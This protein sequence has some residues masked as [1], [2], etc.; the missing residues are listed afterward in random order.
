MHTHQIPLRRVGWFLLAI[1][2]YLI[3]VRVFQLL[4][5]FVVVC[6]L[7]MSAE[8]RKYCCNFIHTRAHTTAQMSNIVHH[9]W[10]ALIKPLYKMC[11]SVVLDLH[12]KHASINLCANKKNTDWQ[13][14]VKL[15]L[16]GIHLLKNGVR[17]RAQIP[18]HKRKRKQFEWQFFHRISSNHTRYTC[19][20][21]E[22]SVLSA[23]QLIRWNRVDEPVINC[24]LSIDI[25]NLNLKRK[26][27]YYDLAL[28]Q[29]EKAWANK[30][31]IKKT[32]DN[33]CVL[34]EGQNKCRNAQRPHYK[35]ESK[36][37]QMPMIFWN[38]IFITFHRVSCQRTELKWSTTFMT[39]SL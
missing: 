25:C 6:C 8:M 7:E 29:W 27:S 26:T 30:T 39:A 9:L 18:M 35:S 22:R 31:I 13:M 37:P 20:T 33:N 17:V 28:S 15:S 3:A 4:I 36:Q 19:N 2:F 11:G 5:F 14:R 24:Q 21:V 1:W 32:L 16:C 10:C 38:E 12:S 34:T 23:C